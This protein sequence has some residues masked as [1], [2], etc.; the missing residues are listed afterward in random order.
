MKKIW[1]KR[2]TSLALSLILLTNSLTPYILA[3][4]ITPSPEPTP[5]TETTPT[6]EPTLTATPTPETTPT[7]TLEVTPEVTPEVIPTPLPDTNPVDPD[8]ATTPSDPVPSPTPSVDL[9]SPDAQG[10]AQLTPSLSTDK[11]DYA[12]TETVIISGS[13]Y[14]P[15]TTYTLVISSQDEP[16]VRYETSITSTENGSIYYAY[17]LDG[18]YRPNYLIEVF[19]GS[20]LVKSTTFTDSVSEYPKTICHHNPGNEVTLTFHNAQSYS[21]HLGTPHNDKVYDTDGPCDDSQPTEEIIVVYHSDLATDLSDVMA[22]PKSWF[23]YNDESNTIDNSLGS[24]VIGPG[25]PPRGDG[26]VEISV[27]GTQRRNLATYQFSGI[28][29]ASITTLAYSTYNP[30][31]GNGGSANR[32]G[33]LGFN[34]DFDGSDTWQKRLLFHPTAN[35]TVQQDTWQK[36]DA[37]N[38]G[39]ALWS[40]SGLSGHGG[41]ATKW[42]DGSTSEY[43]SINELVA[44]F[45]NI[46]I[47]VSDPWMGIRVGEPYSDGY[48]ENIDLFKF[49]TANH[50]TIWDFEPGQSQPEPVCGNGLVEDGEQCDYS[51]LN[52]S[53][54]CS[55]SCQ[56]IAECRPENLANGGFDIPTVAHSKKWDIFENEEVPGWTAEWYGGSSSYSGQDRPSPK[57]EIHAGVNNW[58]PVDNPYVELDSDWVGPDGNLNNE[59]ASTTLSQQVPTIPGYQYT[60]SWKH[61]P[62]PKHNNNH[63]Q[64]KVNGGEVFNSGILSG[65]SGINWVTETHTFTANSD[66]TTISFTELGK[67]DSF[68]MFLDDVSLEC[69]GSCQ[70]I[71]GQ[72]IDGRSEQGIDGWNIYLTKAISEE[73]AVPALN[74]PTISG[75]VLDSGK[76][77]IILASGTYSAGDTITADAEYSV[78]SKFS[79]DTWTD[80]VT[81]YESHGDHLLDLELGGVADPPFWGEYHNSHT[82]TALVAGNNTAITFKLNDFYP[83]NNSGSL[84]VQ[85]FEVIDTRVTRDGGL[86]TFGEMCSAETLYIFEENRPLWTRNSPSSGFYPVGQLETYD[87]ANS[88]VAGTISG[89]KWNDINGDGQR[90]DEPGLEGWQIIVHPTNQDPYQ[91]ITLN[92]NDSNGEDSLPLTAGR[93]YLI[94]AEGTWNNKNGAEYNDADYASTDDWSTYFNYDDDSSRDPRIVDLVIDDQDVDW[95]SY[96]Q[97]HLYK[98]V[99]KGSGVSKNFKISEAGGPISW[100]NDNLGT[101][102]I[103]IYDVTDQIYTTDQDGY[104]TATNLE[105]GEYQVI[106]LNQEGWIQTYP[107]NPKYHHLTLNSHDELTADFG[108]QQDL[109]KISDVTVCKVNDNQTPLSGWNVGL[110]GKKIGTYTVPVNNTSVSTADLPAGDYALLAHGTYR[111]ANWGDA[112]IADA[113]YSLRIPGQSYSAHTNPYDTWV[114]GDELNTP[115]ALE[116]QVNG[117]NV[118]WGLFSDVHEYLYSLSSH[119]GGSLSFKI[120]DNVISDNINSITNPLSVSV[121]QG[122]TGTTSENGCVTFEDVPYGDYT[123]YESLQAGWENIEGHDTQVTVDSST[124]EFTLINLA[125]KSISGFKYE[126][127]GTGTKILSDWAIQ[128]F[129]CAAHGDCSSEPI[130]TT[131]TTVNGYDFQNLTS[132]YYLVKEEAREGW[133]PKQSLSWFVDLVNQQSVQVDFTNARNSSITACKVEDSD[134]NTTTTDDQNIVAGWPISLYQ[135]GQPVDTQETENDG[136]YTWTDLDPYQSYKISE[137]VENSGYIALSD[138]EHTFESL[139]PGQDNQYTFVNFRMGMVKGYKYHDINANGSQQLYDELSNPYEGYLNDW[140]ICLVPHQQGEEHEISLLSANESIPEGSN[141]VLTGAGEWPDGYYE[142]INLGPGTY[143]LYETPQPDWIQTEPSD[144]NG[145]IFTITSGFGMGEG[146]WYN[147]GNYSPSDLVLTKSVTRSGDTATYTLT[148]RNEGIGQVDDVSITDTLPEGFV[149]D[150][151]SVTLTRP[152][153]TT[154]NPPTSGTNPYTWDIAPVIYQYN[155]EDEY[156]EIYTLTYDVDVS[157][158]DISGDHTN[159][160]VANG[161]DPGQSPVFS[162]YATALLAIASDLD[163][164]AGV[165]GDQQGDVLGASTS[166]GQVLGAA[167]GTPSL[168]ALLGLLFIALGLVLRLPKDKI[169]KLI[170]TLA[171]TLIPLVVSSPVLAEEPKPDTTAPSVHIVNLPTYK[172]TNSFEISYTALDAGTSGLREVTLEFR[173]EGQSWQN[174]T[175]LTSSSGKFMVNSSHITQDDKYYFR[176]TACDH[177]GNCAS[178]ETSTIVDRELPPAPESFQ[179]SWKD[180]YAYILKWHNPSSTQSYKVY[181]YRYHEPVFIAQDASLIAVLDVTPN[182]DI[183]WQN[184]HPEPKPYYYAIRNVDPAGNTSGLV[185]DP[186]TTATTTSSSQSA[187]EG[188]PVTGSESFSGTKLV[189]AQSGSGQILGEQDSQ[190]EDQ[191][192]E[193]SEVSPDSDAI[194]QALDQATPEG[195]PDS[196]PSILWRILIIIAV[197]IILIYIFYIR[198]K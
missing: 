171:L 125:N 174:L 70:E 135:N 80:L 138:T 195:G 97:N 54:P 191:D 46:R 20:S 183:E 28:P 93:T 152:D 29:L 101:L 194:D 49:G 163:Y 10:S 87:F 91:I 52:G 22:K 19:L 56:W 85:V 157:A 188:T 127:T 176:S 8:L 48:T 110:L 4:E 123:L 104:Y 182:T 129:S 155:S 36:W 119:P 148:V 95:G 41:S 165:S 71:S 84:T 180:E 94:E 198:K 106:E 11:D 121:Y 128:L 100:Y 31:A 185:S 6:P 42:P 9:D 83:Y 109:P 151:G 30:S 13:D 64:V 131:T 141:C 73:I 24:F 39:N 178:D 27:S 172:N 79:G 158:V 137:N 55:S 40:W 196:S 26:S 35:G 197:G 18:I 170:A 118:D 166:T 124:E 51:S 105:P 153:S 161:D 96:N 3:Q 15:N 146:G 116:I 17:Q 117:N 90:G 74:A 184:S 82:Y 92:T 102:T 114:S 190:D 47:R 144:P 2:F 72:K 122:F 168:W 21:G 132:G 147:F 67:A 12:P 186:E 77:Y 33:Y 162:N 126:D 81:G 61:S 98:T 89:H 7:P 75:P 57:I 187:P 86:Y 1:I 50:T 99:L 53:S 120:Y 76:Q 179:K 78:T 177:A 66:L 45:P 58:A 142:F 143:R 38:N 23:F 69:I 145:Y 34:V 133:S 164:S 43:R 59:P 68:G 113:G 16:T 5:T 175:T 189:A 44:A 25:T 103:R 107:T 88:M 115:G 156:P 167:T 173:R 32:V 149:L 181:I 134:G 192:E 14:Q 130:I 63:L 193:G 150:T 108:N 154:I 62:R 160:A 136:C 60:L 169:K 111:F 65:S 112:G 140:E 159:V 139:T 37:I